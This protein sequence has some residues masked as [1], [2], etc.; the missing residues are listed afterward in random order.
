MYEIC[1]RVILLE[2]ELN[3]QEQ[4]SQKGERQCDIARDRSPSLH[5]LYKGNTTK[6]ARWKSFLKS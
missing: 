1:H 2:M 5:L 3:F 4:S 6:N